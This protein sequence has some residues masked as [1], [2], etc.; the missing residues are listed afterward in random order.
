MTALPPS[1]NAVSMN[2]RS[3]PDICQRGFSGFV[4]I[5]ALQKSECCEVPNQPGVYLVLRPNSTRPDF[6][7]ESIGGHFQGQNPTVAVSRLESKW[8][9]DAVIL[10]IGKAGLGRATLRRRLNQY[11]RFGQGEA[12]GHKGGR[13]IWQ[14]SGS[15]D[16][17]VCWKV[18]LDASPRAVEKALIEEFE[19]LYGKLPFANLNH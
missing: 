14:L 7:N 8:V 18:R 19:T 1:E 12:V 11:V 3:I 16:L 15:G 2:L 10:N 4:T 5:S 17:L 9:D 13:Y 6:L